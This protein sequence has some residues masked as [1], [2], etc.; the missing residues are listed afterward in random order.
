MSKN[1]NIYR[2]SAGSGKT[3]TLAL[4]FIA[5]SL[6]G[7]RY[8]HQDYYRKILA[9]NRK[10]K[11]CLNCDVDGLVYHNQQRLNWISEFGDTFNIE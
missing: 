4:S 3:Y 8:G 5:L 1:F 7:G 11:P 6:K 9:T 2:S 10:I